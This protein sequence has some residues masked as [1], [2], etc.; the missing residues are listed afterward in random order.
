MD[1][2]FNSLNN[3]TGVELKKAGN[4]SFVVNCIVLF[5]PNLMSFHIDLKSFGSN[6]IE[7]QDCDH[8]YGKWYQLVEMR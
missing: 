4:Q 6:N 2:Y 7:M 5:L 3:T 8:R 1:N